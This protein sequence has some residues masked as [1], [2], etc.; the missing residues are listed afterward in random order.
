MRLE[1]LSLVFNERERPLMKGHSHLVRSGTN[2]GSRLQVLVHGS[3]VSCAIGFDGKTLNHSPLQQN[4]HFMGTIQSL[5]MFI[6]VSL[7]Q[8][9]YFV[10]A[11]QGEGVGQQS[12]ATRT[13]GET[14]NM[15]FLR[16][17]RRETKGIPRRTTGR[18]PHRQSTDLL[19]RRNI[20]TEQAGRKRA[21]SH[22]VKTVTLFI[23]R[24]QACRVDVHAE[25]V[26]DRIAVFCPRESPECL[27]AT[28]F[29]MGRCVR[30]KL[31]RQ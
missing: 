9:L 11:I 4:L 8:D 28:G 10:L 6:P 18:C 14:L 3:V 24:E 15:L 16:E 1:W 26:A 13:N 31:S 5:H 17:V 7:E 30:I 19:S 22:I 20:A 2:K 27:Y 25:Q 23:F 29:G 21:D 12:A